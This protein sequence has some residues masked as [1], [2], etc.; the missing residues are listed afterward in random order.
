MLEKK[1]QEEMH[2]IIAL[3]MGFLFAGLVGAA[4]WYLLIN[5]F[6]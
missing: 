3:V 2:E 4:L 1:Q 5:F 6:V